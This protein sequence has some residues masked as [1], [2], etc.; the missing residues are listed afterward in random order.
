M[1]IQ[2]SYV[3]KPKRQSEQLSELHG[4]PRE[5]CSK[6]PKLSLQTEERKRDQRGVNNLPLMPISHPTHYN[7]TYQSGTN[8][9][10][11]GE[12]CLATEH[13]RS[14]VGT[15]PKKCTNKLNKH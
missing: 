10:S 14:K 5:L 9:G 11:K 13:R 1:D 15:V 12:E 6:E 7:S 3:N 4:Q 2:G 8:S